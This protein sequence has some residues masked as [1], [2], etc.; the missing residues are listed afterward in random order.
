MKTHILNFKLL[1]MKLIKQYDSRSYSSYTL[2]VC[3]CVC[4]YAFVHI[5]VSVFLCV[6]VCVRAWVCVWVCVCMR[7]CV[8]ACD[9]S[10][11]F[12]YEYKYVCLYVCVNL[13]YRHLRILYVY[14]PSYTLSP[15][16][17]IVSSN[18]L[19]LYI[20][21]SQCI[22]TKL[23]CSTVVQRISGVWIWRIIYFV[24]EFCKSI[25]LCVYVFTYIKSSTILCYVACI[26]FCVLLHVGV[27]LLG[28]CSNYYFRPT[29]CIEFLPAKSR[30]TI[31]CLLQVSV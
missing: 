24:S 5:C 9:C 14:R 26:Y 8:R 27:K 1:I 22:L 20:Q 12:M 11:M 4:A 16:T 29:Y 6:C 15:P 21:H 17:G 2:R 28:N 13:I 30:A 31:F 3:V 10:F 18:Q 25:Y 7:A 19:G 23:S